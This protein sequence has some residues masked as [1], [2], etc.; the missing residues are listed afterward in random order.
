MSGRSL[1]QRIADRGLS[2]LV[3]GV[4]HD[5][6][7]TAADLLGRSRTKAVVAARHCLMRILRARGLSLPEIGYLLDRD[8]TTVL[9]ALSEVRRLKQATRASADYE[10]KLPLASAIRRGI[11]RGLREAG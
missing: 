4:A 7:V 6:A 8:H 10:R 11:R 3:E 5:H 9:S 2:Q 1:E